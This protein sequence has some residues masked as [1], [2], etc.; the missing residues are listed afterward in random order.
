MMRKDGVKMS[1]GHSRARSEIVPTHVKASDLLPS[2]ACEDLL[3]WFS[4]YMGIERQAASNN[5]L[6]AKK[7]DLEIFLDYLD[8]ITG[9][10]H[11]DDWTRS[12][13]RSF[14]EHLEQTG[15]RSPST[16]NRIL[17]TLKH[18]ARWIHQDRPFLAGNP[19]DHITELRAEAPAWKGLTDI[20]IARLKSAAERRVLLKRRKTDQPFRDNAIFMVLLYTALRVSELLALRRS[21]Y[22]GT[23][24]ASVRRNA[25]L[26]TPKVFVA[27]HAQDVLDGYLKKERPADSPYL[28]C[29][30]TGNSLDRQAVDRSLKRIATA[31]NAHLPHDEHIRLSARVLRHTL[32][33]KAANEHGVE[34]ARELSGHSSDRYIW[35]YVQSSDEVEGGAIGGYF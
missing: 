7:S 11:P 30:R 5:T 20:E 4:L 26:V 33:H 6:K 12:V 19:C 23:H 29:T 18:A 15:E 31:A 21:Q 1:G 22:E 17:A 32:L 35:R 3:A 8:H 27:S 16:I 34:Y 13:T 28:F 2:D 24:F 10:T 14:L 25:R 9:S